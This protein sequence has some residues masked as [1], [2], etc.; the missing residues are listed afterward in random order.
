MLERA[1]RMMGAVILL[2]AGWPMPLHAQPGVTLHADVLLYG[3]NTEFRN[4]FREGETLFGGA[5]R[6]WTGLEPN[7]RV[8]VSL[9][10]LTNGRFG[11]GDAFE[12][13]RPIVSLTVRSGGS[14]FLIGT[15]PRRPVPE[16]PDLG[17]PHGLLPGLQ[18]ETLS[19]ER[20]HEAGLQWTFAGTR[21]RHDA[22]LNWQRLNTP[23]HRER[24]DAGAIGEFRVNRLIAVPWQFHLVHEG[25]QQFASG[26][27][28]DSYAGGPGVLVRRA[29]TA[30]VTASIEAHAL[31]SRFVPDRS[32]PD[33]SRTGAAFFGR[34]VVGASG[35]RGH[36]I[37]WRGDDFIK[38]EGD[39]NYQSRRRDG[40][41]Y[42]G[43]RDYAEAGVAKTFHVAPDVALQ[44]SARIHRVERH[45]EYS[46]RIL[47]S[48]HFRWRI[49]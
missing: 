48:T 46:Y 7:D 45:Y 16:G 42:R 49:R 27:V 15:L 36:V 11:S 23:S 21:L 24:F 38:D 22:W 34:A 17:S 5:V 29:G 3:D 33:R 4:P 13:V 32:T 18:R 39:P 40:T 44:A 6:L 25:G 1:W 20:P 19:F 8:T 26:P 2:V 43:I 28:A 31:V 10:V 12:L 9:G 47:A 35:W 41:R 14:S 30:R 37:F